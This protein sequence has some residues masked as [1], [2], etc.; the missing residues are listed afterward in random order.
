MCQQ[1]SSVWSTKSDSTG[2]FDFTQSK[3]KGELKRQIN[4]REN[5]SCWQLVLEKQP[6]TTSTWCSV[7]PWTKTKVGKPRSPAAL[8]STLSIP[9]P[10]RTM[11]RRFLNFLRSSL[12]SVMWWYNMAPTASFNTCGAR[13]TRTNQH[14]P[15]VEQTDTCTAAVHPRP[16]QTG[17]LTSAV[18][19]PEGKSSQVAIARRSLT[20]GLKFLA[21][22][23]NEGCNSPFWETNLIMCDRQ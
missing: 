1:K 9:V 15:N 22:K 8:T 2:K 13:N 5:D 21:E 19:L 6:K 20:A 16:P 18:T 7:Y 3:R 10:R 23:E 12:P 11:T 17:E 4:L 14:A